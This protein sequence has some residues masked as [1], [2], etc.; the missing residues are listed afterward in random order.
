ML[1]MQSIQM[2]GDAPEN[3]LVV[4]SPAGFS[5]PHVEQVLRTAGRGGAGVLEAAG[6][7]GLRR[8]TTLTWESDEMTGI[9]P[10]STNVP[11]EGAPD[12]RTGWPL[13]P[14]SPRSCRPK[15]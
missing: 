11:R 5:S 9:V 2:C 6:W 1:A 14:A 12:V 8:G 15:W 13:G 3:A 10:R 4:N 7:R